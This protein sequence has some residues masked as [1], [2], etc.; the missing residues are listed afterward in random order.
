MVTSYFTK[1]RQ[2]AFQLRSSSITM[3]RF[4]PGY[5]RYYDIFVEDSAIDCIQV[6]VYVFKNP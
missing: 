1:L 3:K 2:L 5:L 4:V 6:H